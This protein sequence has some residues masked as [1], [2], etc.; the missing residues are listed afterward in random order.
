MKIVVDENIPFAHEAFA[1]IGGREA[2][3]VMVPGRS[4]KREQLLDADALVVRSVTKVDAALLEG[5]PVKFVGTATIGTDHVDMPWLKEQGIAFAS[6]AGCNSQS[7]VEYVIAA[8]LQACD[9]LCD[10]LDGM[11]LGIVGHG[12]IGSRL[13]KVA[14]VLGL[15]VVVCDPPL[16]RAGKGEDFVSLDELLAQSDI[17]TFHVPRIKEGIDRTDRMIDAGKLALMK[18]DAWIINSSRGNVIVGDALKEA[19]VGKCLGAAVLDVWENEP[20][21]DRSLLD[22]VFMGTPHIAGYS[23]EGK[24]NGTRMM[25]EA[26]CAA[27][28]E[29]PTWTPTLPVP[30][31]AI[32]DADTL[33][34]KGFI[35]ERLSMIVGKSYNIADDHV[36][37]ENGADLPADEWPRH[38]D[39]LRR[40]YPV[41][42]E[43][44]NYTVRSRDAELIDVVTRLGFQGVLLP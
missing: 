40:D 25:H 39:R 11:T 41:R 16:Q 2:Q 23:L 43:F 17:V 26:L 14:P 28:G 35:E 15:K 36:A 20:N 1:F 5:T 21:I 37:L 6:A 3:L 34:P 10:G 42:R 27:L 31:N 7:V 4:L 33:C 12:N 32:I 38:F 18:P 30:D 29:R 44:A 13:A 8:M 24:A 22:L 9:M 19:L